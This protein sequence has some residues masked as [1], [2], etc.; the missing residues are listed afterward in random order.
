M[1]IKSKL[2]CLNF[3]L[4]LFLYAVVNFT[5]P[6]GENKTQ[7][8]N[9]PPVV[10]IISPQ[11]NSSFD[12]NSPVR[13]KINVSDK[14]DGDSRYDEI[15]VK[16]VL[17]EVR[18]LADKSK[19]PAILK[20]GVQPD[21]PGIAI[22]RTSNCFNCHNFNGKSIGPSFYEIGKRYPATKSTVD[23]LVKHI[24]DGSSGIWAKEKMPTHPELT[25]DEIKSTVLWIL[26]HADDPD[27]AYY[28]GAMGV[29]LI[30]P[31]VASKPNGVYI[32]TASYV[33][34]GL[35]G[36]PGKQRL[37]REDEVMLYGK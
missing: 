16:Q 34:D 17:L 36:A 6:F 28:I 20:E 18:Y 31:P 2:I 22:M 15:N 3:F 12:T 21:A 5:N 19:L 27:V 35:K 11:N 23:S 1:I 32:L 25:N 7:Q 37:K 33:D 24:K 29:F 13:Y 4:L 8:Q 26:K 30:K 14:E 9:T 10:K